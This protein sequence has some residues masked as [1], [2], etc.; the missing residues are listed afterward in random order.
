MTGATTRNKQGQ[1]L[2]RKGLEMRRRLLDAA[3]ELAATG[4]PRDLTA[5]SIARTA[6][7]A[8]QR[9]YA[10]FADVDEALLAIY[11]ETCAQFREVVRVVEEAPLDIAPE[12]LAREL[13]AS[14]MAYWN[15][16][17][18]ILTI[19]HFLADNGYQD[20][21]ELRQRASLPLIWAVSGR[22]RHPGPT[23][24]APEI[25]A[26]IQA[27]EEA[28]ARVVVVFQSMERTAAR[29]HTAQLS[30]GYLTHVSL[31][32]AQT[33]LLTLLLSP[34]ADETAPATSGPQPTTAATACPT[35]RPR[36]VRPA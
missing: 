15:R 30:G 23:P 2:G 36:R 4:R 11:E 6:G 26:E 14:F 24:R 12:T 20:F 29:A 31:A 21:L 9:F 18:P 34:E 27:D 17:R 5:S 32:Q 8:S 28:N 19:C 25:Q 35:D 3:R 16:H 22:M 13:V 33:S 10:Y 7:T 1:A